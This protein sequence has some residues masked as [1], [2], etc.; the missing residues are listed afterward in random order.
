MHV[1]HGDQKGASESL[2]S[3][4]VGSYELPHVSAQN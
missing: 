1:P 3:G 2:G 4:L